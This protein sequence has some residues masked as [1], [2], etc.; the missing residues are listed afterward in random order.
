GSR[1][2]AVVIDILLQTLVDVVL[3][4]IVTVLIPGII[5]V[6]KALHI[7]PAKFAAFFGA[8]ALVVFLLVI[9]FG[10]F[11]VF[12]AAWNGQTPGKRLLGIRVV[13]DGGYPIDLGSDVLRN[14]IRIVEAAFG[15][16]PS[17]ISVLLSSQ[18]K[19]LGDYAAGTIV[20][21]D[22]AFEVLS[23][24]T[25]LQGDGIPDA[26]PLTPTTALTPQEWELLDRYVERRSTLPPSI[27]AATA[28]RVAAMLR[29]KLDAQSA[30]LSDD[31][32]LM[33]LFASRR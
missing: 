28:A 27:A 15:Y 1:F 29:P 31:A 30:S 10:Y 16:I 11:I 32:V 3:I 24:Q 20:V 23:P 22:R 9:P 6:P 12:E 14:L 13:R 21:R 25:W 33:R 8:I 17:A 18:N 2:L 4:L 7:N 26:P 5:D 19:R